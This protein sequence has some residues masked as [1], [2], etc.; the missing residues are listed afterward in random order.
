MNYIQLIYPD[1]RS[2]TPEEILD[3]ARDAEAEGFIEGG[4]GNNVEEAIRQLEDAGYI[5]TTNRAV[6]P[7]SCEI[8]DRIGS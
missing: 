8:A 7:S 5:T 1:T 6:E 4:F 3:W 2:V